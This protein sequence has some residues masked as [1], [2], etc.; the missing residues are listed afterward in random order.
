MGWSLDIPTAS[1]LS[2]LTLRSLPSSILSANN[3]D[4]SIPAGTAYTPPASCHD[5]ATHLKMPFALAAP[6]TC[7]LVTPIT[8]LLTAWAEQIQSINSSLSMPAAVEQ[9]RAEI[10]SVLGIEPGYLNCHWDA[11]NAAVTQGNA[12]ALNA[13]RAEQ[14]IISTLVATCSFVA[15]GLSDMPACGS[16]AFEVLASQLRARGASPGTNSWTVVAG[17]LDDQSTMFALINAVI[18]AATAPDS[19]VATH[20]SQQLTDTIRMA[21]AAGA[22]L[23]ALQLQSST[24]DVESLLIAGM[25]AQ[26][27]LADLLAS[28][29]S[30]QLS[31]TS[32]IS[33]TSTAALQNV[34]GSIPN[35]PGFLVPGWPNRQLGANPPEPTPSPAP[36]PSPGGSNIIGGGRGLEGKGGSGSSLLLIV[37]A[38]PLLL[39]LLLVCWLIIVMRK[40]RR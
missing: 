15:Q 20:P 7:Y 18:N 36:V 13:L 3:S 14:A 4:R 10:A 39:I 38:L 16:I 22:V 9:A 6:A 31:A 34:Y 1:D 2:S 23:R 25:V 5:A 35:V 29:G 17:V 37:M 40:R 21:A 12:T 33:L 30:G 8:T 32:F 24:T 11:M 28:L 26:D 19:G 27:Y